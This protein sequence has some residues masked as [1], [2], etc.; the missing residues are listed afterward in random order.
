MPHTPTQTHTHDNFRYLGKIQK[1][2]KCLLHFSNDDIILA[3]G[4]QQ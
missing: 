2:K 1:K 3:I 4:L